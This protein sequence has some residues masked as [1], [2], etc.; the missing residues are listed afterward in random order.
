MGQSTDKTSTAIQV[1]HAKKRTTPLRMLVQE[2]FP[3]NLDTPLVVLLRF[4]LLVLVT[5][6]RKI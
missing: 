5:P 1:E 2:R 6:V 4:V 3:H